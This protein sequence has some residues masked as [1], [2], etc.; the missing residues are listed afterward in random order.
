[1]VKNT[2]DLT[3]KVKE[4]KNE[5]LSS[6]WNHKS[7]YKLNTHNNE[8]VLYRNKFFKN[9][10]LRDTLLNKNK[11]VKGIILPDIKTPKLIINRNIINENKHSK[12]S[13]LSK[14]ENDI[15]ENKII[16]CEMKND[17]F[18]EKTNLFKD[19]KVNTNSNYIND[20]T[21][22]TTIVTNSTKKNNF[23]KN[24][25]F[26]SINEDS[27]QYGMDLITVESTANNNIIIPILTMRPPISNIN[28]G[29]DVYNN[30][31]GNIIGDNEKNENIEN[32]KK[33]INFYNNSRNKICKSQEIKGRFYAS[34]KNKPIFNLFPGMQ[35]MLPNFHKIKIEKG[36]PNIKLV[37]SIHQKFKN[38]NNI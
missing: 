15:V 1:M 27:N 25:N 16:N 36:M 20:N 4:N 37:N 2:I 24:N 11:I 29:K 13:P 32:N 3:K 31:N 14:I 8:N 18:M 19:I 17:L 21:Q 12:T 7:N 28:K 35:K 30:Y 26:K 6:N 23:S 22:A 34:M 9:T 38:D 10:P 5:I 33:I